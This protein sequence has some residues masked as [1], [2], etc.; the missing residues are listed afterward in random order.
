L[1]PKN[2]R[3]DVLESNIGARF[4]GSLLLKVVHVC[5]LLLATIPE[6]DLNLWR[7]KEYYDHPP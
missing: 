4:S 5:I 2:R 3:N 7:E 1:R 6:I